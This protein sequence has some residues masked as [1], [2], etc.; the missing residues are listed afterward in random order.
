MQS[1]VTYYSRSNITKRLAEDIAGKLNCD[2][3]EIKPKVNYEGK[4]GYARG[5]KD[6]AT[7]KIV[8]LESLK[9]NPQDYDVV[10]IGAPVWAGKV[11]NPVISYLKQ[12]EGKFNNVK[13][14]LTA[15]SRGFESSFKQMEDSSIKPLKT[16][17]LTTKEVKKENYDL[18]SFLDYM[19]DI[20]V[21]EEYN[22]VDSSK[23]PIG[24]LISIISRGQTFFLNHSLNEFGINYSQ[25]HV[26]YEIAHQ[27]KVNQEKIARRCN[28]NKGAVARS[29]RKLEDDGLVIRKID[30]ENRRQN[31][32]SLTQKGEDTL[33][34]SICI[35]KKWENEVFTE[36]LIN[37][38][39]LRKDLKE[40]A[41][42]IIE[43]NEREI[44][45]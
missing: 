42:R 23:L 24:I 40:I 38:D 30:D 8:E 16:L 43:I 19:E 37:K 13:F 28:I 7:G 18:T 4:L 14:F 3:E 35:L 9:Y 5:A 45:K 33:T 10:Y 6:G 21:N 22:M 12:N 41:I 20:M 31:I 25:L 44:K 2:I 27:N 17:Q 36:E 15:G 32:V 1:L 29:I 39:E 34:K 11:A 26:L